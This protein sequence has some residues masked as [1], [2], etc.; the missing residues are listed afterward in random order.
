VQDVRDLCDIDDFV[1]QDEWTYGM[2]NWN[3]AL[4]M[5][6]IEVPAE[7]LAASFK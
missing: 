4:S 5:S 6:S 1:E 3:R 2:P 7:H